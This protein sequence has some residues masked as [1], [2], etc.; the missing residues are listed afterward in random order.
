MLNFL[1]RRTVFMFVALFAVSVISFFI[2]NLPKGDYVTAYIAQLQATGSLVDA[3]EAINL[4]KFYGLDRPLYIQYFKWIWQVI[5]EQNLGFSFEYNQPVTVVIAERLLLTVILA[6]AT[7]IFIWIVAIPIGIIS[8]VKQYSIWDYIFT[9]LGFI[10]LAIPDFMI[11]LI[12][13]YLFFVWFDFSPGGLFSPEYAQAAWSWGRVKDLIEHMYLPIVVLGTAGTASLIRITRANLLD[14]LAK[15]Y[16]VTARA[17][18]LSEWK[19]IAKY[20]V[21]IALNPAISLTAYILPFL[22]SGS[23]IVGV[24]LSLPTVGPMLVKALVAQDMYLGGGI[25]LLIGFMTVIGT[26]ISDLLLLWI[27]PRIRFEGE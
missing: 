24:V 12:M 14:E 19:V 9:F 13:M 20:P 1:L 8:A 18:G 5:A 4:R 25:I 26:F 11:A 23:V 2:I 22:I 10:G 15:P 6:I 16:V 3:E 17:K 27:D 21:R 7:V